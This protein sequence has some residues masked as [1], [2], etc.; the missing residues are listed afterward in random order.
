MTNITAEEWQLL[1]FFAVE[2]TLVDANVPWCYNHA[3]YEVH[4]GEIVLCCAIEPAYRDV[5]IVVKYAT[6]R[7]YELNA[8]AVK[9]VRYTNDKGLEQ[10]E[11]AINDHESLLLRILPRIELTHQYDGSP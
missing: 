5:H 7:L 2:P 3:V 4:Q 6:E 8:K 1:S 9:D 11:V 10:L